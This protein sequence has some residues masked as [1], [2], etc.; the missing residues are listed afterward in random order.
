M[1]LGIPRLFAPDPELAAAGRGLWG[2]LFQDPSIRVPP[3]DRMP[4]NPSNCCVLPNDLARF[5][6]LGLQF[7]LTLVLLGALGWWLDSRFGTR[8]WLL[9]AGVLLGGVLAFVSLLRSVP[10]PPNKPPA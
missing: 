5:A 7:T 1:S 9:V 6:G 2:T 8:P 10:R 3:G 4:P